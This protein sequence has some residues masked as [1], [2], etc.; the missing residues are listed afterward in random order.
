MVDPA[1]SAPSTDTSTHAGASPHVH[2]R[3]ALGFQEVFTVAVRIRTDR[4]SAQEASSFRTHVKQLLASADEE[5]RRAGYSRETVRQA[6]YAVVAFLDE[7]ILNSPQPMFAEWPRRPLQEEI[8]GD[9]MA[10][11]AFFRDL[12]EFLNHPDSHELA[13]LLEVYQLCLLL[14][15]RGRFGTGGEG[16]IHRFT[17]TVQDRLDRIRGGHPPLAPRVGYPPDDEIPE[18]RDPWVRRLGIA[19]VGLFVLAGMLYAVYRVVL[20]SGVAALGGAA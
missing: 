1:P 2:G 3:L 17:S 16:E 11:E 14:G 8:F 15:F 10:G 19:G 12:G 18:S 7:A 13:D 6:V 20:A 4:Q 9:H 5:A